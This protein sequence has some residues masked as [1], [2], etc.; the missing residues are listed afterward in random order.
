MKRICGESAAVC[1]KTTETWKDTKLRTILEEFNLDDIF[2]ADETGLFFKCLPNCT[3]TLK[4]EKGTG[5]KGPQGGNNFTCCNQY[6]QHREITS[7]HHWK[8]SETKMSEEHLNTAH[9]VQG[10]HQGMDDRVNF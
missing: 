5:R 2:N 8:I 7:L 1:Q 6:E 10:K 9:G 4:G 3:L